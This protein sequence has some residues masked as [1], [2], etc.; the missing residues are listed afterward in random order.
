MDR[1][2]FKAELEEAG[3]F[4]DLISEN[5]FYV[6]GNLLDILAAI[7]EVDDVPGVLQN[8]GDEDGE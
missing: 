8:Y 5:D 3:V 1:Y 6:A 2:E 4:V 7:E